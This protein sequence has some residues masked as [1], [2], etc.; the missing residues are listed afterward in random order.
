MNIW[1]KISTFGISNDMSI[2]KQK[3]AIFFNIAMRITIIVMLL[4]AASMYF[5]LDFVYVPIGILLSLPLVVFSL[6]LNYKG[7]VEMSVFIT[8]LI[9]PLYFLFVSIF[10]KLN[11]EGLTQIYSIIPRFGI[12][13][14]PAISFAVL[15]YEDRKRA[16]GGAI[17][18][19]LIL[20]FFNPIHKFFG[21]NIS[22]LDLNANEIPALIVGLTAIFIFIIMII[23]ILQKINTEYELIVIKQRDELIDKNHEI[24][25]QKEEILTQSSEI[26]VQRDYLA[27]KNDKIEAQNEQ[28]TA[29]ITYASY[30]QSALLPTFQELNNYFPT[31]VFYKPRDIVSGDF[32]WFRK[33]DNKFILAVADCTGHGVPGAFLSMLGISFLNGIIIEKKITEPDKILNELRF[34]IKNSLKQ[35]GETGEQKDGMDIALYSINQK[36]NT[37]QFSGAQNPLYIIRE[38]IDEI[39]LKY[40][41]SNNQI[42][43][44]QHENYTL[45]EFKP[46]RMPIGVYIIEKPFARSE[47]NILES[48]LIYTFSDGYIDQFGG[49]NNEKFMSRRF[50]KLLLKIANESIKE[51][52]KIIVQQ[53]NSWLSDNEQLDDVLVIGLKYEHLKNS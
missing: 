6:F 42:R 35:K 47:F 22:E 9:F 8:S 53:F 7:K 16:F 20:I 2:S 34:L 39:T 18:G 19:L 4:V 46:N 25:A 36:N 45:I 23:S 40:L 51:Q 12:M 1:H 11:G 26:E 17:F 13:I 24:T 49:E 28:I 43:T 32:Y 41:N 50:K 52:H 15:G 30:I 44:L 33:E 31:F 29:S 5:F 48:D 14:M 3:S 27:E 10:T 37:I 21:V 38:K